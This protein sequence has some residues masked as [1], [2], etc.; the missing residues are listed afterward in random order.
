[1]TQREMLEELKV[2]FED[3]TGSQIYK[4]GGLAGTGTFIKN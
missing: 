1:M 4:A 3:K 2:W